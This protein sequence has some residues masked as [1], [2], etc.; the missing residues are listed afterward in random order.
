LP[1]SVAPAAV[2]CLEPPAGCGPAR[3]IAAQV[4]AEGR[5]WVS[6]AAFEGRDTVRVCVTHGET[7]ADDIEALVEALE[8]AATSRKD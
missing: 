2:L 8:S 5:V 4:V 3:P 1:Q 6:A 7:S